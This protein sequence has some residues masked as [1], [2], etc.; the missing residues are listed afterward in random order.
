MAQSGVMRMA[1]RVKTTQ[2][3]ICAQNGA[4]QIAWT[5]Y[6]HPTC[7]VFVVPPHPLVNRPEPQLRPP[8]VQLIN[9]DAKILSFQ[10]V[11]LGMMLLELNIIA[12]TMNSIQN[13]VSGGIS[14]L[15]LIGPPTMHVV[16]VLQRPLLRLFQLWHLLFPLLRRHLLLRLYFLLALLQLSSRLLLWLPHPRA[17]FLLL[18]LRRLRLLQLP[19]YSLLFL[20]E[21]PLPLLYRVRLRQEVLLQGVWTCRCLMDRRGTINSGRSLIALIMIPITNVDLGDLDMHFRI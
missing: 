16:D 11:L 10:M 1:R 21:L 6:V 2:R 7:V 17:Y 14:T 9:A 20:R 15:S 5:A 8:L 4:S 13:V 18:L 19:A 3:L 12:Y